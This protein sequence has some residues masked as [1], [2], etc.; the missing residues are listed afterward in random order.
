MS[1][2]VSADQERAAIDAVPRGLLIGGE[3]RQASSGAT[4]AVD[5][6]STSAQLCEV[7]DAGPE[8]ARDALGAAHAG[9]GVR[10]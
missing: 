3:W 10:P 5:D 9:R 1:K 8:D 2:P 7:A 6:P 4:F